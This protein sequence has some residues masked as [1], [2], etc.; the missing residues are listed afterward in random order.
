MDLNVHL[1]DYGINAS[2]YLDFASSGMLDKNGHV[3][4]INYALNVGAIAVKTEMARKYLGTT[5]RD[6]IIAMFST[7]DKMIETGQRVLAATNGQIKLFGA[8]NF[9]NF[10]MNYRVGG[11]CENEK[12]EFELTK[13]HLQVYQILLKLWRSGIIEN[14][15]EGSPAYN[16]QLTDETHVAMMTCTGDIFYTFMP[17]DPD[18]KVALTLVPLPKDVGGFQFGGTSFG[19]MKTSKNIPVA[20]DFLRYFLHEVEG[21]KWVRDNLGSFVPLKTAF[22]DPSVLGPYTYKN[23]GDFDYGAFYT[24]E[25]A[26]VPVIPYSEYDPIVRNA[27][28]I[29]EQEILV[30]RTITAEDLM[31]MEIAEVKA[32]LPDKVIK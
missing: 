28:S 12:G 21:V 30:N 4:G 9:F 3:Q 15:P 7:V 29:C 16:G 32:R 19:V 14:S 23:F 24:A 10:W 27:M 6:E 2:D 22:A 26:S 13:N 8:M 11:A 31:A 20:V 5:N 25:A 17:N 18:G 1:E